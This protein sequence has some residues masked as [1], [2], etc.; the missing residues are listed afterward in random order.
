MAAAIGAGLPVN[1]TAGV[2]GRRHRRR[3][4]GRRRDQ[5]RRDRLR[6]GRCGSAATRSTRRSS[7]TSRASTPC[8]SA[9][10]APRTSR[11]GPARPSRCARSPPTRVRG[12]DLRH[13]AAQ[14]GVDLGPPR[15]AGPS[16]PRCCRSSSWS[17]PPSTSARRSWPATSSTGHH[18]HRRRRPAP[19]AR[20]AD[21]PRARRAGPRRRRPPARRRARGG[22]VRRGVRHA[23]ARARRHPSLLTMPQAPLR[24]RPV[25]AAAS[26]RSAA[27][28]PSSC[29]RPGRG[30]RGVARPGSPVRGAAA[31][32]LGPLE[33]LA[34]AG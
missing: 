8:C 7:P 18:P 21:A 20:R 13:R 24:P 4:D 22:P 34:R 17:A 14:D 28:S 15:C 6:R 3:H 29:H 19:R 1:D 27:R 2:D 32:V 5:P 23:R 33:R 12:R 9:S 30:R 11:S 26:T 25:A 10:A 16:R 31:A